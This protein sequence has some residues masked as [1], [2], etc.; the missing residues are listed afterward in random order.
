M[1]LSDRLRW[2]L[3]QIVLAFPGECDYCGAKWDCDLE[4]YKHGCN[5]PIVE[6]KKELEEMDHADNPAAADAGSTQ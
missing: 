1:K 2:C 5:C 4:C 3:E 6:M